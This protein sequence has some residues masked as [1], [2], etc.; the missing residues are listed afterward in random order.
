MQNLTILASR[1]PNHALSRVVCRPY[2]GIR[3]SLLA[4]IIVSISVY[5]LMTRQWN[6]AEWYK[7]HF[8][9]DFQHTVTASLLQYSYSTALSARLESS[10]L[11]YKQAKQWILPV[12]SLTTRHITEN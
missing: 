10:G 12:K 7:C 9:T 4:H 8:L 5:I 6:M 11:V 3:H 2:A 1:D